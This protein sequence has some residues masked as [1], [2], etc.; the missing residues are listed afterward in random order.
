MTVDA[1]TDPERA[2]APRAPRSTGRGPVRLAVALVVLGALA[3]F[4]GWANPFG[5]AAPAGPPP[6]AAAPTNPAP[7]TPPSSPAPTP[8]PTPEPEPEPQS[9]R[10]NDEGP[11]VLEI[12][13]RLSELGYWL[14][15]IDGH[16]GQLTR[17]AV[18]AFQK[19]E[20]L[21]R[22]GVAGPITREK[23][24]AA[25]RPEPEESE[26]S[27]GDLIEVD[28]ERQLL[29]VVRDG[30]VLWTFNTSTGSGEAY[31]RPSG[32]SG[33]ASTPRG[34]YEVERQINGIRRAEL[35]VLYRPKY[36]HGGI[37]VHGSGSIP[38]EPASHGCVRLTNDAM[39]LLWSSG[40][41]DIGTEV[42]V[43]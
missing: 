15:K 23:L 1:P 27:E 39:D 11:R 13:Q 38:A 34:D 4:V 28:L 32:G 12:Q 6:V 43:H 14:G 21:T 31:D 16:Y 22:D 35:G 25:S 8:A 26:E 41:A 7:A 40:V 42:V 9:L 33:V 29:M 20:D 3:V 18:M 5:L 2:S 17:Q 30:N 36:F 24:P 19:A 10:L 37:A